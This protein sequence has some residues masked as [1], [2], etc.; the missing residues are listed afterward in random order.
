MRSEG[1][2]SNVNEVFSQLCNLGENGHLKYLVLVR[3]ILWLCV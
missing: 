1:K 2:G 3:S